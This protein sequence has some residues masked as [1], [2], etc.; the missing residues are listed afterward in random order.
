MAHGRPWER[1]LAVVC[2]TPGIAGSELH[3]DGEIV[4]GRSLRP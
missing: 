3:A 1:P 2:G 4:V